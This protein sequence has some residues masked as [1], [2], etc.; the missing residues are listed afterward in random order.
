MCMCVGDGACAG[1]KIADFGFATSRR[2][3]QLRTSCGAH[4]I[5]HIHIHFFSLST[6]N[7]FVLL[8][9]VVVCY[10]GSPHYACPEVCASDVYDGTLA[11]A[12]SLGVLLFV[13]RTGDFPFND[14][15]YGKLFRRTARSLFSLSANNFV[16]FFFFLKN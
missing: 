2:N 5:N 3:N 15:S 16:F 7:T 11:D 1:V 8:V 4:T 9:V 12:W 10:P 13:L 6:H 14:T